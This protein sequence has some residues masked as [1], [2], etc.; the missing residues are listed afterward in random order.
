MSAPPP[1]GVR[2]MAEIGR[3]KLRN[4]TPVGEV[5]VSVRVTFALPV[6]LQFVH[7][8]FTPLQEDRVK[9]AASAIRTTHRFEFMHVPR[10]GIGSRQGRQGQ[11]E[12]PPQQCN[13]ACDAEPLGNGQVAQLLTTVAG[14][15]AQK[16]L[17]YR[18]LL[19]E[20]TFSRAGRI[21]GKTQTQDGPGQPKRG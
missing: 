10:I 11:L 20:E 7:G 15:E 6:T 18:Y 3:L 8:F 17:C 16:A 14:G 12:F 1:L 21:S 4:S 13:S 2:L 9:I 19:A 5:S